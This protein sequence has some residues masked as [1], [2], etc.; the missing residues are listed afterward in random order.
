MPDGIL[1]GRFGEPGSSNRD[2]VRS[3]WAT[4]T[5]AVKLC[6]AVEVSFRE[7]EV[8]L[9]PTAQGALREVVSDLE[10]ALYVARGLLQGGGLRN[11]A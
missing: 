10:R 7:D 2:R 8:G 4:A 6:R 5:Q 9:H 11:D 3:V 1:K